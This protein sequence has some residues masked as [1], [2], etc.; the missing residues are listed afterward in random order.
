MPPTAGDETEH[1]DENEQG[2]EYDDGGVVHVG[3]PPRSA[4]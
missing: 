1:G 2:Y 3:S 4:R